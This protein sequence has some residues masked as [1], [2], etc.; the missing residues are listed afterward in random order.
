MV[1]TEKWFK[2]AANNTPPMY[3]FGTKAEASKYQDYLNR[4][5]AINHYRL[6]TVRNLTAIKGIG[7]NLVLGDE[8]LA[9]DE[10]EPSELLVAWLRKAKI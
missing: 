7:I 8:L 5:R 6:T 3:G 1:M 2:F 9:I 10:N 4:N